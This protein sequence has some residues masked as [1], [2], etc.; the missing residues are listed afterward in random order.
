MTKQDQLEW[1]RELYEEVYL[2]DPHFVDEA[3]RAIFGCDVFAWDRMTSR[4]L[5]ALG[6]ACMT[7]RLSASD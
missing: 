3:F 2:L 5:H 1:T 7:V 6:R 4:Q